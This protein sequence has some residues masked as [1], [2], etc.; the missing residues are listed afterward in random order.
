ML[1]TIVYGV[2]F[3]GEICLTALV[4]LELVQ[5]LVPAVSRQRSDDVAGFI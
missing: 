3:V 5:R 4:G 1:L 2:L